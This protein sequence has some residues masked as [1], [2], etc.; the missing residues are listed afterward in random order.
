MFMRT[1]TLKF[2][3]VTEQ[4]D[5]DDL[6]AFVKDKEVVAAREHFFIKQETP[7]L[8]VFLTYLPGT[9]ELSQPTRDAKADTWRELLTESQL[10]LFNTLRNWRT[11]R[12]KAEG[13]PPYI[14]CT[15]HQ[16]A[17]IVAAATQC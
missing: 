12:A 10:P 15:N 1:M 14:I 13:V 8:V 11:E 2:N 7:Y 4:F 16:L 9:R 17:Q 6:Q 3:P 5:E